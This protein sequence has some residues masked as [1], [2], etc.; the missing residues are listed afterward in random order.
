MSVIFDKNLLF[1]I[2]LTSTSCLKLKAE[3]RRACQ[4]KSS[5]IMAE[6][7]GIVEAP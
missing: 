2:N 4:D 1:F 3:N 6:L 7:R 5:V